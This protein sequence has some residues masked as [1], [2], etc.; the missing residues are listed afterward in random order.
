M[1]LRKCK[2]VLAVLL[3]LAVLPLS[4]AVAG[5]QSASLQSPHL[6]FNFNHATGELFIL[7]SSLVYNVPHNITVLNGDTGDIIYMAQPPVISYRFSII[8][9]ATLR[10]T[11]GSVYTVH[12]SAEQPYPGTWT[13]DTWTFVV[14]PPGPPP[15][16]TLPPPFMP[17]LM[18]PPPPPSQPNPTFHASFNYR[19]GYV[20]VEGNYMHNGVHHITIMRLGA[21]GNI[22]APNMGG[23]V[24]SFST[25]VFN[26]SFSVASPN[27]VLVPGVTYRVIVA[28]SE[29][30]RN[31]PIGAWRA[32]YVDI[33][34]P[35]P[36]TPNPSPRPRPTPEPTP[37]PT[38]Q[39]TE[40]PPPRFVRFTAFDVETQNAL[41]LPRL[42]IELADAFV[43][44]VLSR[45]TINNMFLFDEVHKLGDDVPA[46]IR[47]FVGDLNL[48]N[49]QQLML[50]GF[51]YNPES[52]EYTVIR[53]SFN[54]SRTY[55]FFEVEGAG[56][57]GAMFYE[58]PM[59]LLRFTIG[60]VRYYH[61]GQPQTSDAA[62]FISAGRTMVPIRT[63]AEALGATPR[64]DNATR[65]AYIYGDTVLRLPMGVPL[66]G[67][68]GTPEMSNNRILVPARFVIE[69]FDAVTL[70]NAALQEVTVYVW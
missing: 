19:G 26:N 60:Q 62:P 28:V 51:E 30:V 12:I 11:P 52:G 5:R 46:L 6:Y 15:A 44:S 27:V 4:V 37:E 13:S 24:T 42:D 10:T 59:P 9:P 22:L 43:N 61:N 57:F 66:P 70:W 50:T 65:T 67:G 32:G 55:F 16:P 40:P 21:D 17:P 69:N 41:E 56:T 31:L 54:T 20:R 48:N 8:I 36:P 23:L 35:L 1:F 25:I 3:C 34:A 38:P 14:P 64:W 29:T 33:I 58:R 68:M 7:G 63:I 47:V 2:V 45:D 18:P 49:E 53:G 39:P